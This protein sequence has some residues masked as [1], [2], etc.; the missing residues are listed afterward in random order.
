M[1]TN[2]ATM[3]VCSVPEPSTNAGL[4]VLGTLGVSS[5]ILRLKNKSK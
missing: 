4:I 3:N 5:V 1:I 2:P